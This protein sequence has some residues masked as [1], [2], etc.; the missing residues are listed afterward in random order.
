V[1]NG[2]PV[3]QFDGNDGLFIADDDSLDV[4]QMTLFTVFKWD[5]ITNSENPTPIGKL[6][7]TKCFQFVMDD[8]NYTAGAS[9]SI[10]GDTSQTV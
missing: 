10:S 6:P 5:S 4:K 8:S 2:Q 1:I 9:G 3:F 7:M